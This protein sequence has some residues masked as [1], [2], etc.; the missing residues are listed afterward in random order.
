M[1]WSPVLVGGALAS[2]NGLGLVMPAK[3]MDRSA[4]SGAPVRGSA[5]R[6][7]APR[8]R[9]AVSGV[10]WGIGAYGHAERGGDAACGALAVLHGGHDQL[11][12]AQRVATGEHPGV[13]G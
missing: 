9:S 7:G 2:Q 5:R 11:A 3:L 10:H 12:A 4:M 8:R 13:A 6:P 1:I